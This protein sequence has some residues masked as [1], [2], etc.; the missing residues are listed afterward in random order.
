MAAKKGE[1]VRFSGTGRFVTVV[2]RKPMT[3]ADVARVHAA[4]SNAA[5]QTGAFRSAID[6]RKHSPKAK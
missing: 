3:K 1:S 5:E 4:L 6:V 2:P